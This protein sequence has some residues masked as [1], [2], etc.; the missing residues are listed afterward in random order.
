MSGSREKSRFYSKTP[1][2]EIHP[3][4]IE[5]PVL[6]VEQRNMYLDGWNLFNARKFWHAHEAWEEVWKQRPEKSRIFFQGIIQL[7]AAYHLLTE[8]RPGGMSKNFDKAEKKLRLCPNTF[9]QVE[10]QLLLN[11]IDQARADIRRIG[12]GHLDA[13]DMTLIPTITPQQ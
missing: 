5:E 11:G 13:F 10:V 4:E 9:L 12:H 1:A 8:K 2:E 3:S 6:S 7:A